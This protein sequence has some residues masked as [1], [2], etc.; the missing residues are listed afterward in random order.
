LARWM[1]QVTD[2]DVNK[3]GGFDVDVDYW[4]EDSRTPETFEERRD[5][6]GVVTGHDVVP[7]KEPERLSTVLTTDGTRG[8]VASDVENLLRSFLTNVNRGARVN[9]QLKALQ[10]QTRE[11]GVL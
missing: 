11:V 7:G 6:N 9:D 8:D 4:D 2:F 3:D 10:G 1:Y 5:D